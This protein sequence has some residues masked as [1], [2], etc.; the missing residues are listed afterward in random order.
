MQH[1]RLK[2]RAEYVAS[3]SFDSSKLHSIQGKE[4]EILMSSETCLLSL[5]SKL[6]IEVLDRDNLRNWDA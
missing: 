1:R 2:D 3:S 4:M 5:K 6:P